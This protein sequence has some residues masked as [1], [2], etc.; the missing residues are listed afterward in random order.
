MPTST[1]IPEA[2]SDITDLLHRALQTFDSPQGASKILSKLPKS[3]RPKPSVADE[4]LQQEVA[5]GRLWQYPD[6][7]KKPQFWI[8]SPVELARICLI[9]ELQGGPRSEKAV[10]TAIK[11]KKT[12]AAVTATDVQ[13]M[14]SEMLQT[15]NA[16]L[17]PPLVGVKQTKSSPR[18]VSFF[19]PDPADYVKDALQKVAT[20]LGASFREVLQ[21]AVSFASRELQELELD[22]QQ[23][24]VSHTAPDVSA[25]ASQDERLLE[26]MRAMNPQIDS[27]GMVDIAT[28]RK[29]LDAHMPG[30]DFD[31]AVLDAVYRQRLA[32]HRF[33]RPDLILPVE[34]DQMLRN[35]EGHFYNTISLW[36]N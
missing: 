28:L 2:P 27:G 9:R 35:E 25:S 34:R 18:I 14:L 5:A 22:N 32:I 36:R 33:D 20:T 15:S 16:Y 17:C 10:V 29:K 8:Q 19:K 31:S 26:A 11:K 24:N 1:M 6:V 3:S 21:S 12:L 7:R 30:E 13:R 4:L 23:R